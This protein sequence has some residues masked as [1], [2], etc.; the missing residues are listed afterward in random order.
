MKAS[1]RQSG[2]KLRFDQLLVDRGLAESRQKAQALILA[3]SVLVNHQK[4][5]KPG[6]SVP[7]TAQ[8]EIL[9]TTAV[10]QPWRT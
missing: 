2:D 7:A 5:E 3:G 6:H 10:C 1:A 8:I 9:G 4:A